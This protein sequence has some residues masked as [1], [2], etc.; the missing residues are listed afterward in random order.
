MTLASFSLQLRT[1]L[2][3]LRRHD[4][5][6]DANKASFYSATLFQVNRTASVHKA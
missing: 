2:T 1:R 4:I 3:R 5:V 6:R